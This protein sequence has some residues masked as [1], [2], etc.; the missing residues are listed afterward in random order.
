[1]RRMR[2][3]WWGGAALVA[4]TAPW[5]PA[6]GQAPDTVV[7]SL[8]SAVGSAL[9]ISEEVRLAEARVEQSSARVGSARSALLPSVNTQLA[10]T[11][12]LRSVF[13]GAGFTIDDSLKFEPDPTL[14]L[15]ERVAYL[16]DR[17]P[18]AAFE[19]LG[20]LFGNLP[21][22]RE[23]TWVAQAT[24]SQPLFAGGRLTSAV[25]AARAAEDAATAELREARAGVALSVYEAYLG[26]ALADA[27]VEIVSASVALAED[28][29]AQIRLF[30]DAGRASELQI[31]RAE[32]ELA[33]L[34]PQLVQAQNG[35]DLAVLNLKRLINIPAEVPVALTTPLGPAAGEL[36]EPDGVSLPTLREADGELGGRASLEVARSRVEGTREQVD[37]ARGAYFPTVSLT[38]TF[39]RQAFPTGTFPGAGDW[40]DDWNVGL[41]VQWP[42]FQ[43]FRR[44]ADMELARAQVRETELQYAQLQEGVRLDYEQA[45]G[46]LQRARSQIAAASRTVE[47]AER[48]QELTELRFDEGIATQLDVSDARL[49]L[50]QARTN[51]VQAYHD[52]YIAMARALRAL[53]RPLGG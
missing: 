50:Q 12:T 13:Q 49:A 35:R 17:T 53:G 41:V 9:D 33:N 2:A 39:A 28:H 45:R 15:D 10:Y 46:E 40:R 1:M 22:G 7:V 6:A 38:G 19:A 5:A 18:D 48:V 24:L 11:R 16:E 43:G 26:A 36:P 37:M 23:N 44:G 34:R 8:G 32:V 25:A 27:T 3:S 4:A 51:Q 31:M 29:L 30:F 47:Q 14:P 21:F 52:F 42:L 20:G